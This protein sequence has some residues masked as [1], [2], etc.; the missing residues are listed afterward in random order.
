MRRWVGSPAGPYSFR[1][2]F[3]HSSVP[4][5]ARS[6]PVQPISAEPRTLAAICPL[7]HPSVCS[8][9]DRSHVYSV[10]SFI[11][12]SW[13]GNVH[14]SLHAHTRSHAQWL[15]NCLLQPE[16]LSVLTFEGCHLAFSLLLTHLHQFNKIQS[17]CPN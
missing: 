7:G 12:C 6:F 17:N 3:V 16:Q 5:I 2:S 14:I 15:A 11:Q 1:P 9:P 4:G 13:Q 8:H 10:D